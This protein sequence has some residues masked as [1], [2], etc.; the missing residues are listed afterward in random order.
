M[1]I[2]TTQNMWTNLL[3]WTYDRAVTGATG[4]DKATKLAEKYSSQELTI[5]RQVDALINRQRL[6]AGSS[7]FITGLGGLLT[8]PLVIPANL[9]SVVFIQ[10]RMIAAIAHIGGYDL[11]DRKVKTLVLACMAGNAVKDIFQEIGIRYGKNV[12]RKMVSNISERSLVSINEKIGFVLL[13]RS[14]GK[15]FINISKAI[16]LTGGIIGASFDIVTTS[17]I[18]KIAKRTFIETV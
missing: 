8:L 2:T 11:E 18:G 6:L 16:P 12:T 13:T 14:G 15:G 1:D 3:N 5:D 4:I 10:L 17:L 9:I 7:G